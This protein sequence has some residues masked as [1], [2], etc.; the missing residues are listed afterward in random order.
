MLVRLIPGFLCGKVLKH[1]RGRLVY[2]ENCTKRKSE[3]CIRMDECSAQTK[4]SPVAGFNDTTHKQ[5]ASQDIVE[6]PRETYKGLIC[7]PSSLMIKL[8]ELKPTPEGS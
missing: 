1:S 3:G 4:R 5:V 7:D 8:G 6:T 2:A